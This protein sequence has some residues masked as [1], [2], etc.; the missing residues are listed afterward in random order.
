MPPV[1]TEKTA[2]A[3]IFI[4]HHFTRG[5]IQEYKKIS[6]Q[7]AGLGTAWFLY[8]GETG[9]WPRKLKLENR[10]SV[11]REDILALGYRM[12][13]DKII[14]GSTHFPMLDFYQKHPN[15]RDYWLIEYDVR[16]SGTW[17][18]FFVDFAQIRA[19]FLAAHFR[20]YQQEPDWPFWDL[21]HPSNSI[22]LQDRLRCFHPICRFSNPALAFLCKSHQDGWCGHSEVLPSSLLHKSG[23]SLADFGGEGEFVLPGMHN[24]YYAPIPPNRKGLLESGTYR[25]RPPHLFTGFEKDKLYHPIKPWG[26]TIK[27]RIRSRMVGIIGK[28]ASEDLIRFFKK[29]NPI[30]PLNP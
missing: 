21:T 26:I 22:P 5:I 23:Y 18:T 10:E 2:V 28:K 30:R 9:S 7:V 8:Q 16:F 6:A 4:A 11:G 19:D 3:F 29:I 20:W 12:P 15:Y 24:K 13:F 1:S 27:T 14:P 17:R 25:Y